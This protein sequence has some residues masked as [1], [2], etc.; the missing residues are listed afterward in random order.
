M[1]WNAG[2]EKHKKLQVACLALY[3]IA[4]DALMF[5]VVSDR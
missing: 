4:A 3:L 2:V 1:Q 5:D